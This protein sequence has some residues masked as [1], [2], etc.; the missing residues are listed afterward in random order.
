MYLKNTSNTVSVTI[1]TVVG[2]IGIKPGEIADIKHKVLP[3]LSVH[4]KQVTEGDYNTFRFGTKEV[5]EPVETVEL[6]NKDIPGETDTPNDVK[7]EEIEEETQVLQE[8]Y[9]SDIIA[10]LL[11]QQKVED[12]KPEINFEQKADDPK[13]DPLL[14]QKTDSTTELQQLTN[15]ID[16]LKKAWQD[17]RTPRKKEKIAKQ[18]K[19]LQKQVDKLNKDLNAD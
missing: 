3:P 4:I 11:N 14:V 15:Q 1:N 5:E 2:K 19:E 12:V 18:I 10:K 17:V 9:A 8:D 13:T 7:T 6:E 16:E